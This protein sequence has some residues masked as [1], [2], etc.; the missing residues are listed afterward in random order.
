[1]FS[2]NVVENYTLY[3]TKLQTSHNGED[4]GYQEL[5]QFAKDYFKL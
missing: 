2:N 4:F 1:M 3:S 5:K